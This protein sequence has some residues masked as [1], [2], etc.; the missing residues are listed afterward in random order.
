M[1]GSSK[2]I[3]RKE[4]VKS[5]VVKNPAITDKKGYIDNFQKWLNNNYRTGL[6]VDGLYGT[7]TKK[8]AIKGLQTELNTQF[9]AKK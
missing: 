2:T 4:Q 7:I 8:A 1:N 3:D 5:E 6:V 9:G